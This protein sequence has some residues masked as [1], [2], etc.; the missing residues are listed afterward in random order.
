MRICGAAGVVWARARRASC[1]R[2]PSGPGER[3]EGGRAARGHERRPNWRTRVRARCGWQ[4]ICSENDERGM[5][6]VLGTAAAGRARSR[7]RACW[8]RRRRWPDRTASRWRS[9]RSDPSAAARPCGRSPRWTMR[10]IGDRSASAQA[11]FV[12]YLDDTLLGD[13]LGNASWQARRQRAGE[14]RAR[15]RRPAHRVRGRRRA[16]LRRAWQAH[17]QH[18]VPWRPSRSGRPCESGRRA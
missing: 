9:P 15:L 10:P 6:E 12:V 2:A 7:Q 16:L 11:D 3:S 17:S 4:I 18:G 8:A 5:I 14:Q 1:S 13:G